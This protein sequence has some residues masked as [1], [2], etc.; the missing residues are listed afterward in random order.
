M[1]RGEIWTASGG[2]AYRDRARRVT[3]A[4]LQVKK[5]DMAHLEQA[6]AAPNTSRTDQRRDHIGENIRV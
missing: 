5:F 6:Y 4:M 2:R 1:N 3:E